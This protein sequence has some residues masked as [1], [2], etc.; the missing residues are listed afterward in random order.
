MLNKILMGKFVNGVGKDF[1]IL[2]CLF[3]LIACSKNDE[4]F[5]GVVHTIDTENMKMLVI[6]QLQEK[7]L[8]K[9]YKELLDSGEYPQAIWVNKIAS[10]LYKKGDEIEVSFE[11]SDDSFPAQVTAKE[12]TIIKNKEN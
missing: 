4:R 8:D 11:A 3:L 12:V 2:S 7:D 1:L 10:S 5:N 6:H 9:D